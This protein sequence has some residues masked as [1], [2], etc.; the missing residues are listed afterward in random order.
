MAQ[1]G[2]PDRVS[3]SAAGSELT[4]WA[5]AS[6]DLLESA[7]HQRGSLALGHAVGDAECLHALFVGQNADRP[8]PVGAPHAAIE[9][10]GVKDAKE[11]IPN[12]IVGD[13]LV[14]E[15]AGA[16]DFDCDVVAGREGEQRW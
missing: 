11:R 8:R 2:V 6:I 3:L 16:A 13:R 15:R 5:T 12:I 14:R 10:K 9:T 7:A 1:T 4:R